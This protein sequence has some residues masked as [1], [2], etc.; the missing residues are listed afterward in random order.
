MKI[1]KSKGFTL[2]ELLVVVAIIGVLATI[3]LSS[4]SDARARSR[5]A[6]RLAD[7]RTI[8]AALEVY[9]VDN[10]VYP[11]LPHDYTRSDDATWDDLETLLGTTLPVDPINRFIQNDEW[12]LYAYQ[13]Y[14]ND[15]G[16]NGQ[17][18]LIIFQLESR[19]GDGSKDGVLYCDGTVIQGDHYL[20]AGVDANGKFVT[21]DTSG[22]L[23]E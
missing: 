12:F 1:Q 21:P 9:Y 22:S 19:T 6:K 13:A 7:I 3:V 14:D 18:Y 16:C 11:L 17:A 20:A 15:P 5:D 23:R 4:L 2:I 10:G 8:Q